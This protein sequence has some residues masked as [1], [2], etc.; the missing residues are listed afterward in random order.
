MADR[1]WTPC[2]ERLPP[3]G[4]VVETRLRDPSVA[5]DEAGWYRHLVREGERWFYEGPGKLP[6]MYLETGVAPFHWR[7]VE[8]ADEP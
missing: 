2:T 5:C 1:P 4:L 6:K 3:E 7:F 8:E